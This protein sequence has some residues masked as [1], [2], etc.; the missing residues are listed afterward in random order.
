MPKSSLTSFFLLCLL[1]KKNERKSSPRL[2]Q[3]IG[4]IGA[5]RYSTDHRAVKA[6][7]LSVVIKGNF[8]FTQRIAA[9]GNSP[10]TTWE[11]ERPVYL[12]TIKIDTI[13][14]QKPG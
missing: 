13:W 3:N 8:S 4:K 6:V 14:G 7:Q 9:K 12:Q 2:F 5:K 10:E 11:M 1:G